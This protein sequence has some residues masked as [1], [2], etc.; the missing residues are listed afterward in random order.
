MRF[1]GFWNPT[2][3]ILHLSHYILHLAIIKGHCSKR[4]VRLGEEL[5]GLQ[6]LFLKGC[7]SNC[8]GE[9]LQIKPQFCWLCYKA[10]NNIA[11]LSFLLIVVRKCK[12]SES[13]LF[14][15]GMIFFSACLPSTRTESTRPAVMASLK[16]PTTTPSCSRQSPSARDI[17]VSSP[18]TFCH[19]ETDYKR[20]WGTH[21]GGVMLT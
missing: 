10:K 2:R 13:D 16:T 19:P 8:S 20:D 1:A 17:P 21:S 9:M 6:A 12:S 15:K 5:S 18:S 7:G 3:K 11:I 4:V 14:Y